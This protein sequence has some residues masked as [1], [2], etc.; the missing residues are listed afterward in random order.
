MNKFIF[1]LGTGRCGTST[2]A[3]VIHESG[4]ACMGHE[5]DSP[6]GFNPQ[7]YWEDKEVRKYLHKLVCGKVKNF[8]SLFEETHCQRGC[9]AEYI[10]Y[11]HPILSSV[12]RTTWEELNPY[13]V[14][15][16][17]R[18][19]KETVASMIRFR[20]HKNKPNQ[21]LDAL[22]ATKFLRDRLQ[23]I[24]EALD[25]LPFVRKIDFSEYRTDE[26][27]RSELRR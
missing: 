11:K 25:S 18:P 23:Q 13:R 16:C 9:K 3:R 26:W 22:I 21:E 4:M 12:Q 14:Y 19:E 27:I 1:V 7:G 6:D 20:R 24:E 17:W 5:F 8:K 2:T 15:W 10:G